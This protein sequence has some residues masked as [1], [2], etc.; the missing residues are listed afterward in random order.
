[1]AQFEIIEDQGVSFVKATLHNETIQAQRGALCYLT[2]SVNIDARLPGIGDTIKRALAEQTIIWPSFSGTGEVFLESSPGGFELFEINDT[3][4]MLERGAYWASEGSIKLGLH[5]ETVLTSL[6]SGEGMIALSTKVS[7]TGKIILKTRGP[8]EMITLKDERVVADGRYV[9]AR[10]EGLKYRV[11]R[12]ARSPI[13]SLLSGERRLRVFEGTGKLLLSS[14]PYWR[15]LLL[16]GEE[17][18]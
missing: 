3:S 1:M 10:T 9:L 17:A 5:R 14:Y 6:F 4:W 2:G 12:A 18:L 7:G 11:R 8:V 15:Y 13:V 16:A